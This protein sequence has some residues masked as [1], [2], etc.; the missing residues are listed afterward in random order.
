MR[1]LGLPHP[2]RAR[3]LE[4]IAGDLEELRGELVRRGMD[5]A[6]AHA[7]AMRLLAPS[8]AALAALASVHEPL[9]ASLARRFSSGMRLAEW[10]GLVGVT[11][12][13]LGMAFVS[14]A[15][16]GWIR[17]PSLFLIPLLAVTVVVFAMAGRKAIQLYVAR[18]HRPDR[19]DGGMGS[20]LVG[21]GLAVVLGL[22]GAVYEALRLAARLEARPERTGELVLPWL[23]DTSILIGAGLATALVGG[24]AWFLLRQ[25]IS[26]VQ[27]ADL[28]AAHAVSRAVAPAP[29]PF[30]PSLSST[31]VQR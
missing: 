30:D 26:A 17:G 24:L 2:E 11:L 1:A 31:G 6:A 7:E 27:G 21:S 18:D 19:L 14:L 25:T 10:V 20:L 29:L 23:V 22:G 12:V 4:E 9:Y 15:R 13:A 5:A 3:V 8:G 16:S 28:R